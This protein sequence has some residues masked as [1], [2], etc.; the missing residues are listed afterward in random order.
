MQKLS[1]GS[2][3]KLQKT[4]ANIRRITLDIIHRTSSPHIGPS[5]SIIEILVYLY[6]HRMKINPKL[7]RSYY[8]KQRDRFILSKGHACASLYATLYERGFISQEILESFATCGCGILQHHPDISP[9]RGIEVTSGSLGHGLSIAAGMALADKIDG[10]KRNVYVLT[11]DGELNEGSSWEAILFAGHHK[12]NRLTAV[13]DYNKMQA[14]GMTRDILELEPLAGKWR[15]FGWEAHE[16]NGHDFE[17]IDAAFLKFSQHK[18]N[19]VI[20]HTVKGKGVSFMENNLLWHYR[21][22][23]RK[24]YQEALKEL[25][26]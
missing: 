8:D 13:V 1:S 23:D 16:V 21:A 11:S 5:F 25:S 12:L 3:V 14:L 22:P 15:A 19:V 26:K 4:A 10:K 18:P 24:E 17:A 9:E 20:L 2:I 7:R 6:F